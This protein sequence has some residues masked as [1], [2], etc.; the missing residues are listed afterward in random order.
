MQA[1]ITTRSDNPSITHSDLPPAHL[2]RMPKAGPT[3]D[4]W[5][6]LTDLR[7]FVG[8]TQDRVA[9][10]AGKIAGESYGQTAVQKW[11]TGAGLPGLRTVIA[12]AE[13]HDVCVE[14]LLTGRGPRTP[15]DLD[16]PLL[17]ELIGLWEHLGPEARAHM[18][19][20]AKFERT[21]Q[22]RGDSKRRDQYHRDLQRVTE[23]QRRLEESIRDEQRVS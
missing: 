18:I 23:S 4:F 12:I 3:S 17:A 20:I 16:D 15:G 21:I 7:S 5:K 19:G 8:K 2:Q 14:W 10:T 11:K 6:R 13:H 1:S 22:Y 9:A